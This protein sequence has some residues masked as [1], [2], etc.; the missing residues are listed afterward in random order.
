MLAAYLKQKIVF[1]IGYDIS[2][3]TELTRL[4]SVALANPDTKFMYICNPPRTFQ[5]DDLANGFC[6]TFIKF[7][8]LVDKWQTQ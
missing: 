7:Q 6:D 1:L 5:L 2:N 8:E 3:P 4:K